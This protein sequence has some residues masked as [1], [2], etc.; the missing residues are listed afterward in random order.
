GSLMDLEQLAH[1][2][3]LKVMSDYVQYGAVEVRPD[4]DKYVN[5]RRVQ[6]KSNPHRLARRYAKRHGVSFE[7]A[8]GK[9]KTL[10]GERLKYPFFRLNSQSTGQ[11]FYLFIRQS[12]PHSNEMLGDFN[13]F[14]LSRT[15]SLPCF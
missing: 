4:T 10:S 15:A 14:G 8:F 6:V 11:Q 13:S 2:R 9:Y 12:A 5:V 3:C 1:S 7:E